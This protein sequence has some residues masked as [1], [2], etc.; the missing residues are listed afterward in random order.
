MRYLLDTNICI[1]ALRGVI[2]VVKRLESRPTTDCAVSAIT[3]FEL[4]T[5]VHKC[6]DK[7]AE[8]AKVESLLQPLQQL[9]FDRSAA[10]QAA[11]IRADLEAKGL[12]I[13][14]YD[15]LLAAQAIGADLT[16]VTS[17]ISEFCRVSGLRVEDWSQ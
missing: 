7:K 2:S 17:N 3:A 12:K 16:L 9:D 11:A 8:Q 14:P 10:H 4:L 6:R 15:L 5:G 13:G 1:A